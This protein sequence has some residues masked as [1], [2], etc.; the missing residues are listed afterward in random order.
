M[1]D[2]L[3]AFQD[4]VTGE[5]SR[6]GYVAKL[7]GD[8]VL[9]YF[10]WP[11]A[12]EN[13]AQRAVAAALAITEAVAGLESP[14][15]EK[16]ACRIGIATGMVV[17]GE[18]VGQGVAQEHTVVGPTPNLAARLQEAA[19]PGEIMIAEMTRR[20]LGSGFLV[21]SIS[22]RLLKGHKEPVPLFRVLRQEFRETRF[23]TRRAVDL[24]PM[25]G[26]STDLALLRN[27]WEQAK[28]GRGARCCSPAR[29]GSASPG[30]CRL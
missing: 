21:E 5:I 6:L 2:V 8:G 14:T 29:P 10:G 18:L 26:R 27:A 23:L 7:M 22:E 11:R 1:D 16:L 19:G 15:G 30:W 9:A 28:S 12:H 17:V 4:A 3:R 24:G 13:D 25:F 20:L